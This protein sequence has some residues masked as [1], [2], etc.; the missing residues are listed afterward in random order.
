MPHMRRILLTGLASIIALNAACAA[1]INVRYAP[2]SLPVITYSQNQSKEEA[3]MQAREKL[4][5]FC[6]A[7]GFE[8]SAAVTGSGK[9]IDIGYD[10]AQE[11]LKNK[12]IG[13]S[14][15][16]DNE[17]VQELNK[18]E[19]DLTLMHCHPQDD[20]NMLPSSADVNT[21][22][23]QLMDFHTQNP[24][25]TIKFEVVA[26][27]EKNEIYVLSY[28]LHESSVKKII[29]NMEE[30]KKLA[31]EIKE[32]YNQDNIKLSF[33]LASRHLNTSMDLKFYKDDLK[34]SYADAV[35]IVKKEYSEETS[36]VKKISKELNTAFLAKLSEKGPVQITP[37]TYITK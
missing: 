19:T 25:G 16:E 37:T 24:T 8:D 15:N 11:Y 29:A 23:E 6:A 27:I 12:L 31:N 10:P 35:R 20:Y 32:N 34:Q 33:E 18:T 22:I 9:I 4:A 36:A 7:T 28:N 21:S 5:D 1:K 14:T 30:Q 17:K 26:R 2:Q 3:L 13:Y